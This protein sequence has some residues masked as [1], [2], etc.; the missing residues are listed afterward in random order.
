MLHDLVILV[1]VA[2]PVVAMA[3]R[4]RVPSVVGFL[5]TGIAVG[6]HAL[7][8]IGD[9]DAVA[10]LAELGV[11]LLLFAIGLELS[12]GRIVRMGR[13]VFQ[14][15]L[16]QLAGT[17]AVVALFLVAVRP[18]GAAVFL[19]ALVALS[20]TA[21]VLKVYGDRGELDT[22]YARVAVAI[23]LFQ[24]L[25]IVPLLIL[26]PLVDPSAAVTRTDL[27]RMLASVAVLAGLVA[28]GRWVVPWVL[29]QVVGLR[30]RELFTLCIGLFGLV[31]AW[32]V[33]LVG[34]SMPVGA[35]VAGLVISESEYG[36]QA[37]SDVVPF[38]DAF[39]GIFFMSVGMLADPGFVVRH[40][41]PVLA[42]AAGI[43]LVKGGVTTLVARTLRRPWV[44]GLQTGLALAQV[45]EFS[46]ILLDQ[47]PGGLIDAWTYQVF[48]A[49]A[50]LT[51]LAAP[52]LIAIAGPLATRGRLV[53]ATTGGHDPALTDHAIIVGYGL[54]GRRLA[55]V[56]HAAGFPFVV[57][58]QN[59]HTVRTAREQGMPVLFGDGSRR[60]VLERIG[61]ARARVIVFSISAPT[62][63][64]RGVAIARDLN[65]DVHIIVRTRYVASIDELTRLGASDVVVEEFE[66][67]LELFA[68]VLGHY[69]IPSTTV[70]EEV[71]AVR[72]EHYGML[73]GR[74]AADIRVDPLEHLAVVDALEVVRVEPGAMAVGSD[75]ASLDL[76]QRTGAAVIAVFRDGAVHYTPDPSLAFA[77][78]DLVVL[79]GDRDAR[80][81]A[82]R[83]LGTGVG[84]G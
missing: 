25:A 27:F 68:K 75:P 10:G 31:A 2:V 41:V 51:M 43:V 80:R 62:E 52:F 76:R 45:G 17:M 49:A 37:L 50:V 6:P 28:G 81:A 13:L 19:G 23:V 26:V 21:I 48:L 14:G 82:R 84:G 55:G 7:G 59:G 20:S 42:A 33:S 35:F 29:E 9:A 53:R 65:P 63:E 64:R 46:F 74:P 70:H 16:L 24:D 22:P 57:L 66:A 12:L 54:A 5:V 60:D 40:P 32:M 77:V 61:I 18:A 8:L 36:F 71:E 38:R 1:V 67:A 79:I 69:G 58:E 11:V 34:L 15:G 72:A 47:A 73:R 78:G 4:F 39:S 30:N 44:T 3:Q 83:M 56:L